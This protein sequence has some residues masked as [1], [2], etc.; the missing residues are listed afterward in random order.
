MVF[1]PVNLALTEP[2]LKIVTGRCV[3]VCTRYN[4]YVTEELLKGLQKEE[5][6]A[7]L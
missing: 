2:D 1:L 3:D 7:K 4:N 5:W 6:A